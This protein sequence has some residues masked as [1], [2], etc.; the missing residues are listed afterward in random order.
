MC[1]FPPSLFAFVKQN[2]VFRHSCVVPTKPYKSE[3]SLKIKEALNKN[4]FILK[5]FPY[6]WSNLFY[7]KALYPLLNAN[8]LHFSAWTSK[9]ASYLKLLEKNNM[10]IRPINKYLSPF[11]N[12]KSRYPIVVIVINQRFQRVITSFSYL[13]YLIFV[14]LL[15][16]T[17]KYVNSWII[18]YY[19]ARHNVKIYLRINARRRFK[20]FLVLPLREYK[21]LCTLIS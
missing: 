12:E 14:L 4:R 7:S 5:S 13:W 2:I 11:T 16:L 3:K 8:C 1:E 20:C 9:G 19:V 18:T 17:R 21:L 6:V 10:L 15:F